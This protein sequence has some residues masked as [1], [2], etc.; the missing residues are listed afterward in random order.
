MRKH[1]TFMHD[2]SFFANDIYAGCK[3]RV[4]INRVWLKI[5]DFKHLHFQKYQILNKYLPGP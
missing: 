3:F 4:G 2:L 5:N 1:F